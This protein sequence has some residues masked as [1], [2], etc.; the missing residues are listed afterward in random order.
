[1]LQTKGKDEKKTTGGCSVCQ[2]TPLQWNMTSIHS[3]SSP[4]VGPPTSIK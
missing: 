2:L 3:A 4:A 1:M